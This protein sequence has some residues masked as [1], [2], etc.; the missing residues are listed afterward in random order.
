MTDRIRGML[1][2][3]LPAVVIDC[4]TGVDGWSSVWRV[5]LKVAH[6]GEDGERYIERDEYTDAFR[7]AAI[8]F[9]LTGFPIETTP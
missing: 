1:T 7:I 3:P 4:W 8:L 9:E 5:Y 6:F 2:A